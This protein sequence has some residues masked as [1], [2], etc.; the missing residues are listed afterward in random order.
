MR[1]RQRDRILKILG[2]ECV[3]CGFNDNRAL[4]IDHINGNGISDK[5]ITKNN[6]W[7]NLVEK[8]FLAQENKY[9]LLCANCNWIKKYENDEN[10]NKYRKK[11]ETVS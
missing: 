1:K 3:K 9:Q 5:G 2:G 7:F 8:S 10:A 6:K 4:Q 11:D